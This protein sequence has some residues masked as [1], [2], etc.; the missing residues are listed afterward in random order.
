MTSLTR[1]FTL[2][3]LAVSSACF[4]IRRT[5]HGQ[6]PSGKREHTPH[7]NATV[8][9]WSDT[10]DRVWLDGRI[11]AN[12]MED[13]RIVDGAAECQRSAGNRNLHLITHQLTDT[14]GNLEMEVNLRQVAQNKV[15]GG[16]GFRLGTK[17]ELNEYRSNCFSSGG[18]DA[19]LVE[20]KLRLGRKRGQKDIDVTGETRLSL[21][22]RPSDGR[23][24]LTLV[25][26]DA[27]GDE[28]DRLSQLFNTDAVLGNVSLVNNYDAKSKNDQGA[29]YRLNKWSVSGDA[30]TVDPARQFGPI[31]WS[32]YSLSDSRTDEG[33]VMKISALTGPLG[34]DDNH[35]VELQVENDGKWKSLGNATLDPDAWTA[36]FR[37]PNWD[38]TTDAPY[39]LIYR[40]KGKSG[41]RPNRAGAARS[42]PI[43]RDGRFALAH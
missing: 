42:N 40:E 5:T 20:G 21:T 2:K 9:D 16:A 24:E 26:K 8:I 13:W 43:L 33:F 3:L 29:R 17:S 31:L 28:L 32:M 38:Q 22:G 10:H 41:R 23:Y 27:S 11:W 14:N 35:E 4:G 19:G 25:A 1:R 30:F 7:P 36:T 37:I 18:I 34:A 6:E 12:P 15:D 39:Q